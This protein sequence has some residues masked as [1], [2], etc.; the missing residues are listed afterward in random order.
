MWTDEAR[1]AHEPRTERYPSDMTDAEWSMI[2]PMIPPRRTGGRPRTC[3][4]REWA[5]FG[6]L[7]R[8][9]HE[10][11]L[12]SRE[13]G[14]GGARGEPNRRDHRHRGR[15]GDGKRRVSADPV[16]YDA[17]MTTKGIKRNAVTDTVGPLLGIE[18]IPANIQDR[19][20]TARLIRETRQVFP[21]V[22][23]IYADGG[24]SSSEQ[25]IGRGAYDDLIDAHP[26]G[27]CDDEEHQFADITGL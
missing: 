23:K 17:G 12:R 14:G 2:E 21:F 7:D 4:M 3:D 1:A 10:L 20:C 9:H 19:D 11:L 18:V 16:A 25:A 8:I 13:A 6:T 26:L 24:Y 27:S 5:L 15:Q 22:T